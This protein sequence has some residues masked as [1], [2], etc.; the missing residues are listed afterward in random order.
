MR[1]IIIIAFIL[2]SVL[3]LSTCDLF[4][5]GFGNNVDLN[6]PLLFVTSHSNGS[7]VHGTITIS[8]NFEE[9]VAT[10]SI[11]VSFDNGA[12]Y[13]QAALNQ[14]ARTWSI[15][16]DTTTIT[17]G[18]HDVIFRITDTSNKT[19]NKSS[20]LY[21]DN[22][23]P[24][25]VMTVPSIYGGSTEY[26]GF[27][28]IKG[29]T[30]DTFGV[31]SVSVEIWN[32]D[33]SSLISTES[34]D[35]TASWSMTFNSADP[36]Y[37]PLAG[38]LNFVIRAEDKAGNIS[39]KYFHYADIYTA[40]GNTAITIDNIFKFYIGAAGYD[41]G[42][43]YT[44]LQS[45]G[46]T[47]VLLH[48]DQDQ[49]KPSI[50]VYNPDQNQSQAEN[51]LTNTSRIS[52]KAIDGDGIAVNSI[53]VRFFYNDYS[54]V[55]DWISTGYPSPNPSVNV[56]WSYVL[57]GTLTDDPYWL[58]VR[59]TDIGTYMRETDFIGFTI[60]TGA[61]NLEVTQP[62][63][64]QYL[65]GDF[66]ISGTASD[67]QGI[68]LVEVGVST[69]GGLNYTFNNATGT[70][71]WSYNVTTGS[72]D[73]SMLL[74][75]RATDNTF[76]TSNYNLQVIID[77]TNPTASFLNPA[78]SS[79][80]NGLVLIRG[81]SSDN[82]QITNAEIRLGKDATWIPMS[83][84]Y[85]WEYEIDST[86]YANLT[87]SDDMGGGVWRLYIHARITDRAGNV[88]T[89]DDFYFLIDNDTD[90]PQV[91]ILSPQSGATIGGSTVMSGTAIDDD[92]LYKVYM[93]LDLDNDGLY[94][95]T[96]NL[97]GDGTTGGSQVATVAGLPIG[98]PA[99]LFENEGY[100]YE[101]SGTTQWT[102]EL[103]SN[104][105]LYHIN[106]QNGEI[107]A[108]VI[109]VDSKDGGFNPD[110]KGNYQQRSF[111]FDDTIPGFENMSHDS[112]SFVR[113]TFT[114]TGRA[115]DDQQVAKV[116]ISYNGGVNWTT[117]GA[118]GTTPYDFSIPI[119]TETINGGV[120]AGSSGILYLRLRATDNTGYTKLQLID[121]KVDN[122]YPTSTYTGILADIYG[123]TNNSYVQGTA[124]D[125]GTVSGIKQVEVY[126]MR[127]STVYNP[128]TGVSTTLTQTDF[129]DGTG[130]Q[131]YTTDANYKIVIDNKYENGASDL[132]G[133]GFIETFTVQGYDTLWHTQFNSLNITD[134]SVAIHY[135]AV[136]LALNKHHYQ[137]TGYIKNYKPIVDNLDVGSDVDFSNVVDADE[138]YDYSGAIPAYSSSNRF[139]A[140]SHVYLQV[141]AHDPGG[142]VPGIT[143]YEFFHEGASVQS[144]ASNVLDAYVSGYA[145]GD[146]Y[147]TC[148]IT[149]GDNITT[150]TSTFWIT[151]DKNDATNP[152]V[153]IDAFDADGNP[154]NNIVTGHIE[155]P[156]VSK[157]DNGIA[158]GDGT[159]DDADV[160]GII[161]LNG[162]AWDNF[163]VS[164]VQL[165]L[166]GLG[167]NVTV[168]QWNGTSHTLESIAPLPGGAVFTIINQNITPAGGHTV[169]WSYRWDT[170]TVTNV[171][172]AN[173]NALFTSLDAG[174]RTG[175]NS[176]S[177]DVVPYIT[178]LLRSV[179]AEGTTRS[180]YGK[181]VV[182]EGAAETNLTINGYNLAE[183]GTNWTRVYRTASDVVYDEVA[184]SKI[185]ANA[186]DYTSLTITDLADVTH[187]G[188]LRV[189]VNGVEAVNNINDNNQTNNKED[190]G[191]GLGST[192]W[193]DD[194]YLQ[195]WQVGGFFG[196]AGQSAN[197]EYPSMGINSTGTLYGAWIDRAGQRL[198]YATPG[199][200]RTSAFYM[201]DPP[202][203][204][205]IYLDS[206]NNVN[207]AFL[208]NQFAGTWSCSE[209][210]DL[211]S[212]A[213]WVSD[214]TMP[215]QS[216][217]GFSSDYMQFEKL[218]H[219]QMLL[220]F[221]RPRVVRNGDNFHVVYYDQQSSS[222]KYAYVDV[223]PTPNEDEITTWVNLDGGIDGD[224]QTVSDSSPA[225][226][227]SSGEFIDI[228][229]DED[230][231]PVVLYYDIST[232]TLRLARATSLTP[233]SAADWQ[234][235]EVFQAGDSNKQ[236][237]GSYVT[238]KFD[239]T[240]N[241]YVACYNTS[242]GNLVY[243][244]APNV[245][246]ADY[247]FG[248]STTIDSVGAVGA[249]ADIT[250]NGSI[251]YISYLNTSM[252][253]TFLG[254]KIAYYDTGKGAWEYST[255][256]L[257]V[258]VKDGR[259]NIEYA[260]GAVSW[261]LAVGYKGTNFD[262]VYLKP[263][264]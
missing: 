142:T 201:Y 129:G 37:I 168:A 217:S 193:R 182:R 29:E 24:L 108:R 164:D 123:S 75:V 121:L 87:Y 94:T 58:K 112:N 2:S 23:P 251:P 4:T 84:L 259:T 50:E 157:Y 187:S 12:T 231:Y 177:Y 111:R 246:G 219:N 207:I 194:R 206:N 63:Q 93:C 36:L 240:G 181:Y 20:M 40:N 45:N 22:T 264:E 242:N 244:Y 105:E 243:L 3:V 98:D 211:G 253:G 77:K 91:S 254:L 209:T 213:G 83:N 46:T 57:D 238:M 229:L 143:N 53:Q 263:E 141:T 78:F 68:S 260:K 184:A 228:A 72:F 59:A 104:G 175:V 135:V 162:T 67:A 255:L 65:N 163:Y 245:D 110:I 19:T 136:D 153:S 198:Y 28:S 25:V 258:A 208:A 34:A 97:N 125:S 220:Q 44:Y 81:T 197:G 191:S 199:G 70:T 236:Y 8:G 158:N 10:A 128:R 89:K 202:E 119:N 9:D 222:A 227:A 248:A 55:A 188:V 134:G 54:P 69:D 215:T 148:V 101:V 126:F 15:V 38:N 90:K 144:G 225:R 210:N 35:G 262:I 216:S 138:K 114:L 52:G 27:V 31:S 131:Y 100:W 250:L 234:R 195:V 237:T 115:V 39:T 226:S 233:T 42:P 120:F 137:S 21:F 147:F 167:T 43:V 48:F 192:L 130:P 49:N 256:P 140:R 156:A 151:V 160:S 185:T 1:K 5:P 113:K 154:D 180:K 149:D 166:D 56:N 132:D 196:T 16:V 204:T 96:Y 249:W 107:T 17:D 152:T 200:G 223:N 62:T 235:Q 80:V 99:Q 124:T 171:A 176:T 11:E 203:F 18:E 241:V 47:P 183:T 212:I 86:N 14:Q 82:T 178:G 127:G 106:G 102:V 186:P 205:D 103:N 74:K 232:Q 118:P 133:D 145:A 61:P 261:T 190:D 51:V 66:T 169:T 218:C 174:S 179:G 32:S 117:V 73:G 71:A 76:K 224:T 64:G 33:M 26:Y 85:N 60:D 150:T 109:A 41:S 165:T 214:R 221:Q 30:A 155:L 79:T 252:V 230:G 146:T 247:S 239:A 92:G 189:M 122:S 13:S 95:H 139:K 161:L 116:E 7:Y 257:N 170:S 172:G 159:D 6:P 88:F 173:K